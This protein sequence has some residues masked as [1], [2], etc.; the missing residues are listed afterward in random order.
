MIGNGLIKGCALFGHAQLGV[1]L[2]Q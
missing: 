1:H 2:N